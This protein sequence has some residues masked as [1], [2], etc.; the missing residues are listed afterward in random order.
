MTFSAAADRQVG[1]LAADLG[2]RLV[3]LQGDL[4]A[5]ARQKS[6]A[7]RPC[8]LAGLFLDAVRDLLGLADEDLALLSRLLQSLLDRHVGLRSLLLHLLRCLQAPPCTRR[9][10]RRASP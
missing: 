7:L 10:A 5:G 4:V 3:A 6:L 8:L 1:E 2:D 9:S